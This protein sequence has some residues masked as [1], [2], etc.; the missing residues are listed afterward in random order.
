MNNTLR[1]LGWMASLIMLAVISV[2]PV[3][4]QGNDPMP[5]AEEDL[6][7]FRI[8]VDRNIFDPA[9]R[10]DSPQREERPISESRVDRIYL[11]GVLV[12]PE[13]QLAF[14]EGSRDEYFGAIERGGKI[15]GFSVAYVDSDQA[16]LMMEDRKVNL[17]VGTGMTRR[18]G[19]DWEQ[20]SGLDFSRESSSTSLAD[21]SQSYSNNYGDKKDSYSGYKDKSGYSE[22]DNEKKKYS[23]EGGDSTR[24]DMIRKM[25]ERRKQELKK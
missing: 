7:K 14:F 5:T 16:T 24:L 10:P 19:E 12:S 1:E 15:A 17:R 21:Q 20:G 9:R 6:A 4:A 18:K 11:T 25:K 13:D 3:W 2:A 22:Y 23:K 8:L